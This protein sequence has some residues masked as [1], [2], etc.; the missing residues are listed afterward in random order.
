MSRSSRA[1]VYRRL[2]GDGG[3]AA[4]W[5]LAPMLTD[6]VR[7]VEPDAGPGSGPV[8]QIDTG[9]D[10][11]AADED[12]GRDGFAEED[13]GEQGRQDGC[14]VGVGRGRARR[15]PL[16]TVREELVGAD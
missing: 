8:H 15:H 2:P 11:D 14:E 3:A 5:R 1:A 16:E 10:D 7:E 4:M 12:G 9:R 13:P 6:R